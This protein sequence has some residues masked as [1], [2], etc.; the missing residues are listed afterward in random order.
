M[1]CETEMGRRIWGESNSNYLEG[2]VWILNSFR[3]D[4]L[5]WVGGYWL[6]ESFR[7]ASL[8]CVLVHRP[9]TS[10][11]LP[12][13]GQKSGFGHLIPL[14]Q[15]TGNAW[16]WWQ[17]AV[18][19]WPFLTPLHL[20]SGSSLSSFLMSPTP[21]QLLPQEEKFRRQSSCVRVV[22]P[23]LELVLSCSEQFEMVV[24][25][26]LALFARQSS[27]LRPEAAPQSCSTALP[28]GCSVFGGLPW[29][30]HCSESCWFRSCLVH[31]ICFPVQRRT[32]LSLL[33][34]LAWI[35]C[36]KCQF[37]QHLC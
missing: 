9:L 31:K 14:L 15:G 21:Q 4:V 1:T 30:S 37:F 11:Y 32:S 6:R 36:R 2:F 27:I 8:L 5:F 17:I 34:S 25:H 33:S 3:L 26:K 24:R 22:I 23:I 28:H 35:Y 12:G 18:Q 10:W 20:L 7:E 16:L 19:A 13:S 29:L